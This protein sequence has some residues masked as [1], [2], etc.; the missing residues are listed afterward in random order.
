MN[1]SHTKGICFL[2]KAIG[3]TIIK[4]SMIPSGYLTRIRNEKT[5]IPSCLIIFS[6]IIDEIENKIFRWEYDNK[7]TS[8]S[9]SSE[10]IEPQSLLQ[11]GSNIKENIYLV[12]MH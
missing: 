9:G 1:D 2:Q 3:E 12:A 7:N 5:K 11:I 4:D 10:P 8:S 6:H